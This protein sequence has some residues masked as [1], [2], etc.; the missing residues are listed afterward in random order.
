MSFR[1]LLSFCLLLTGL[2][3]VQAAADDPAAYPPPKELKAFLDRYVGV[4]AG[5]YELSRARDE[6]L[7]GQMRAR[8]TYAWGEIDGQPVL[9]GTTHFRVDGKIQEATG[10]AYYNGTD[11]MMQVIQGKAEKTFVGEIQPDG[12][13]VAWRPTGANADPEELI[14]ER[15]TTSPSREV[16]LLT[17]AV[18]YASALE[19]R[20]RLRGLALRVPE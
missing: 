16:G 10:I 13:T 20:L 4:W 3:T 18:E 5:D 19:E 14:I 17:D 7:V 12:R 9:F 2:L 1:A 6:V 11:L 8:H 15:F